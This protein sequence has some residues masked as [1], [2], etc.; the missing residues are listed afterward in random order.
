MKNLAYFSLL[1]LAVLSGCAKTDKPAETPKPTPSESA[2][3]ISNNKNTD[4]FKSNLPANAPTIKVA[5]T[6]AMPPFS[7]LDEK[8][9]L[10]GYDVDVIRAIGE[11]EGFK[12]EFVK[13]PWKT[14]FTPV[15]AGTADMALSGISYKPERA[16]KYNLTKPY[17]FNPAAIMYKNPQLNIKSIA[18]LKGLRVG[19]MVDT[20]QIG[21]V[22]E[23]KVTDKITETASTY[24]L[25]QELV[26]DQ[27]D[28]IVQDYPLL[29]DTANNH[30]KFNVT[31]VPYETRNDPNAQQVAVLKKGNDKLTA[32][33]NEGIDKIT[34]NG[35]LKKI[36]DK[37][38]I[39]VNEAESNNAVSSPTTTK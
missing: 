24:L 10:I 9:N 32:Q 25:F 29:K 19:G 11:V 3:A 21:T 22:K 37:W 13:Q 7:T 30:P 15:E 33:I 18:D 1:G 2:P 5:T 39:Q 28:A 4:N 23:A 36:E 6:G 17:F 31:I 12:V 14:L 27:V 38:Q 20:K 8:G 26:N 34:A 35:T 16:E